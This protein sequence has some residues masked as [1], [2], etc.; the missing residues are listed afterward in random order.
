MSLKRYCS[1]MSKIGLK[2]IIARGMQLTYR[3]QC[4]LARV[5]EAN[6]LMRMST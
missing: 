4:Y 1:K 3:V 2:P 5:L 6:S